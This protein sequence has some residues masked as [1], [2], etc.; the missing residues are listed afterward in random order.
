[1]KIL[2]SVGVVPIVQKMVENR[3][4]QFERV[5]KRPADYVV[6]KVAQMERRQAIQ[7]IG[8]PVDFVVRKV[9]QMERR[10]TIRRRGRLKKT[11]REI[12]KKDLEINGLDRSTV[13]ERTL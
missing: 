1:M 3:L 11:I 10:Q 8:R 4:W 6:R 7:R 2:E 13:L 12:I 9:T 5:E